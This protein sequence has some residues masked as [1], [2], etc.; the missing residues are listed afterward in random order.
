MCVL[1]NLTVKISYFKNVLTKNWYVQCKH[2]FSVECGFEIKLA[3]LK[4][5]VE[6]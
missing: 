5:S 6:G 3:D 4:I 1:T 2:S